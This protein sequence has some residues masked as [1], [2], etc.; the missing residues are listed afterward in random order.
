MEKGIHRS[1]QITGKVNMSTQYSNRSHT[2][3][4]RIHPSETQVKAR[5][6]LGKWQA[7]QFCFSIELM[8]IEPRQF[9][10]D[11]RTRT[12][13][14]WKDSVHDPVSAVSLAPLHE[15]GVEEIKKA[16]RARDAP[17]QQIDWTVQM[18]V[19][20]SESYPVVRHSILIL[21]WFW[22]TW[23]PFK[24]ASFPPFWGWPVD[25]GLEPCA[26]NFGATLCHH[27][28]LAYLKPFPAFNIPLT[29]RRHRRW[30]C[31][32]THPSRHHYIVGRRLFIITVTLIHDISIPSHPYRWPSMAIDGL[33]FPSLVQTTLMDWL[34]FLFLCGCCCSRRPHVYFGGIFTQALFL[35]TV[36]DLSPFFTHPQKQFSKDDLHRKSCVFQFVSKERQFDQTGKT[37]NPSR[38]CWITPVIGVRSTSRPWEMAT[39]SRGTQECPSRYRIATC[40]TSAVPKPFGRNVMFYYSRC[41][42]ISGF[43]QRSMAHWAVL[44][45]LVSI[46]N[47]YSRY[48]NMTVI[49]KPI[50]V[51]F[52]SLFMCQLYSLSYLRH[53][54]VQLQFPKGPTRNLCLQN[55]CLTFQ[56][57]WTYL[58]YVYI[59]IHIFIYTYIQYT[60]T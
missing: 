3:C 19:G 12:C 49:S 56:V 2:L 15:A 59:Y 46:I 28:W 26:D 42:R 35:S 7:H 48:P 36:A 21:W 17:W 30:F 34:C 33:R 40:T 13:S 23:K 16:H 18:L 55:P 43:S 57:E 54:C 29:M 25:F 8:G 39:T 20:V 60:H 24:A 50:H 47:K 11:W 6:V 58:K 4:C 1:Y 41:I 32:R 9:W 22:K 27:R 51:R 37:C 5:A 14:S 38:F 53:L 44:D 45:P 10:H 31:F 52:P